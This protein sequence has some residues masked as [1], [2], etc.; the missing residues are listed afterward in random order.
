MPQRAGLYAPPAI[1]AGLATLPTATATDLKAEPVDFVL[2]N[3]IVCIQ[4]I[5]H[6]VQ[7]KHE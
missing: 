3:G 7:A 1:S 5:F 6:M 4:C 2:R